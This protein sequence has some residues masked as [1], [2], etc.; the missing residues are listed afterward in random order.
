MHVSG[1]SQY[2]VVLI[3]RFSSWNI[4]TAFQTYVGQQR[5]V[6]SVLANIFM[7]NTVDVQLIFRR[8]RNAA[9][10]VET[11]V[12]KTSHADKIICHVCRSSCSNY[13]SIDS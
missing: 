5:W 6:I 4:S 10:V 2:R 13:E 7:S 8:I 9:Y 11:R 1:T 3:A 12:N